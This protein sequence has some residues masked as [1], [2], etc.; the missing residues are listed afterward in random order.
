M[1]K[2]GLFVLEFKKFQTQ[3]G[4][5]DAK[6]QIFFEL[7]WVN[8]KGRFGGAVIVEEVGSVDVGM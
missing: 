5:V 8:D 4:I 7:G 3:K 6:G 2:I 1:N